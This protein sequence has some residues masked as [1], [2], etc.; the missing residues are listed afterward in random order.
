[1]V[2]I[3]PCLSE[4]EKKAEKWLR[5]CGFRGWLIDLKTR[6]VHT[7]DELEFESLVVYA[8]SLGMAG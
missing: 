1:M 2:E 6:K 7:D 5:D 4:E 3:W 8:E